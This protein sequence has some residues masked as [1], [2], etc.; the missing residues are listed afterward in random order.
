[1]ATVVAIHVVLHFQT[2]KQEII[3]S[4]KCILVAPSIE[5]IPFGIG[6]LELT[7]MVIKLAA[8]T[9]LVCVN[10]TMKTSAMNAAVNLAEL[11]D[12]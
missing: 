12:E 9:I 3:M 5:R 4:G 7:R 1:M 6:Y 11:T 10:H 2:I 8:F